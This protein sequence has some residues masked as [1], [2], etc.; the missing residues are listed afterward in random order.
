M[1]AVEEAPPI[2][3]RIEKAGEK[4]AAVALIIAIIVGGVFFLNQSSP[5]DFGYMA[6][7][8]PYLL[9]EG[10]TVS[11]TITVFAYA[12]G[13]A[14]GFFL[15]W[16][17]TSRRRLL[18]GPATVYVEAIRG[19]PLFVQLLFIFSVLSF[20]APTL[21]NRI[22]LTGW[23]TLMINTSGYQAEIFRAG[24][25][26]VAAGQVEAAKAVG[27][28]YWGSMRSVILPQAVRLVVPPLTNEFIA[29]LKSSALLFY[30]GV[31]ELTYLGRL[32]SF[33]GR[34]LEVYAMLFLIYLLITVPLGKVVQW[35]EKR[36]RI[37]G[38]GMQPAEEARARRD[39]GAP[40]LAVRALMGDP[41]SRARLAGALRRHRIPSEA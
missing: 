28:S 7:W 36:F 30:I 10:A 32:L 25:Q 31:Q 21:E 17:R 22:F 19:T 29:L 8:F 34:L 24:L 27:L 20:Y 33:Q 4:L 13:V 38:V 23:V 35:L 37:P 5:L 3:P 6:R 2:R 26:S 12:A 41:S 39:R 9:A 14:I 40:P 18:R 11:L 16:L 15:G 1:S